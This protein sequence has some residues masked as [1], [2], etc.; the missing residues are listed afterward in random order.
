MNAW[1]LGL[2][3]SFTCMHLSRRSKRNTFELS[4]FIAGITGLF[5]A[6]S[7]FGLRSADRQSN[8]PERNILFHASTKS[9][10]VNPDEREFY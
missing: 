9:A 8:Y 1:R 4:Y 5:Y 2:T 10:F 7:V 3:C 6:L